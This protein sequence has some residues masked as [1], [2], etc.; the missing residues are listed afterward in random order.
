VIDFPPAVDRAISVP[1]A[2]ALN[3]PGRRIRRAITAALLVGIAVTAGLGGWGRALAASAA[4][5]RSSVAAD[6][7]AAVTVAGL[8]TTRSN[9]TVIP[10][11][12]FREMGYLPTV[13]RLDGR[14]ELV[15]PGGGCS[16]PFGS[17]QFGFDL[18][19]KHH[20]LGYDVLRYAARSGEPLGPS[21]RQAIDR[22]FGTDLSAR[23][24]Q[25]AGDEATLGRQ[26]AVGVE[27]RA[28]ALGYVGG[29]E[30]NSWRQGWGT[31]GI[32]SG[33]SWVAAGGMGL[34]AAIV[35]ALVLT[36]YA[37]HHAHPRTVGSPAGP[38]LVSDLNRG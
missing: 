37:G 7:Q 27:C 32:E 6:S 38:P 9:S 4:P 15:N 35:A 20:D 17:T 26:M 29:V 33:W 19:C 11:D 16:S 13:E 3:T 12:F 5:T 21:A 8:T 30:I 2:R 10:S 28:S 24:S 23:C 14:A 22:R 31:P 25:V 34:V 1:V 18:A 36:G